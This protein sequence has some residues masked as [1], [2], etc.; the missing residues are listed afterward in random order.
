VRTGQL[1]ADV[2]PGRAATLDLA[3]GSEVWFSFA[4]EEVAIYPL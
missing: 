3:P 1:A 2:S 4:E